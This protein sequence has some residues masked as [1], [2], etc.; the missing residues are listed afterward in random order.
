VRAKRQTDIILAA[1]EKAVL[2]RVWQKGDPS[3]KKVIY[4]CYGGTH[5]SV[6]AAAVHLSL[7]PADRI[8]DRGM[9]WKISLF[10]RQETY[11]HGHIFFMGTDE[12][13]HEVYVAA[14][15]SRPDVLERV[16]TGLAD[17]FNIPGYTYMLVNVMHKV[18]LTMRFGGFLSRRWGFTG[19]GRPIVTLG[20]QN[21]YFRVVE[22][23]ED[24]KRRL[25]EHD[26]KNT[27]LQ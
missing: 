19:I 21:A 2:T 7:L 23:V 6:T 25:R 24:V 14:R 18:N 4:H 11:Q 15:R 20:T 9:F 3:M 8:P 26:E 27:V 12:A 17:I 16:F 10:D 5:S 13:G 22:L 1:V